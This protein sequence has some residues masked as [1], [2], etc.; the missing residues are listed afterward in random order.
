MEG[1]VLGWWRCCLGER[2]EGFR[3]VGTGEGVGVTGVDDAS[4][5]QP[6]VGGLKL[7]ILV[8][9]KWLE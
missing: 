3:V 4:L 8:V 2:A 6:L 5:R 7:D 9:E 1:M